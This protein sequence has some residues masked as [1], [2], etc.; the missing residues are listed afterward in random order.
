LPLYLSLFVDFSPAS[1]SA[2]SLKERGT[3]FPF[4]CDAWLFNMADAQTLLPEEEI[5]LT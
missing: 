1:I 4:F 5:Y 3:W 2:R